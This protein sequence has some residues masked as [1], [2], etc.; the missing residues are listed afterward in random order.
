MGAEVGMGMGVMG[1]NVE[2]EVETAGRS[3][4]RLLGAENDNAMPLCLHQAR[5]TSS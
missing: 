3:V 1:V 2:V 4:G 5:W